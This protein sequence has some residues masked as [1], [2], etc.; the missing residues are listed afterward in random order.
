M[1]RPGDQRAGLPGLGG[2]QPV[3][4]AQGAH[5]AERAEAEPRSAQDV[6]AAY[7]GGRQISFDRFHSVSNLITC[8]LRRL[9]A[10]R[11]FG[12]ALAPEV[13]ISATPD[14]RSTSVKITLIAVDSIR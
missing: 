11:Y 1:G 2:D 13:F 7:R 9:I 6:A 10:E 4:V 3:I 12:L 8:S 5:E 14:I